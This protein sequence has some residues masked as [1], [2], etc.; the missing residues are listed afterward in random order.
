[1]NHD[2]MHTLNLE[3]M[4]FDELWHLYEQLTQILSVKISAEKLELEKRLAQLNRVEPADRHSD[5]G[6]RRKYPKVHPKY[7]NPLVPEETWSGRGKRPRWLVS[8]LQSGRRLEEFQV[9]E[10]AG[11]QHQGPD[12]EKT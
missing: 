8:A 7:L 1:M 5:R 3:A 4:E 6:P 12:H 10:S 9:S 2:E 11:T